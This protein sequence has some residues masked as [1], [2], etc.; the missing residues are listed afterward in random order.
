MESL[1]ANYGIIIKTQRDPTDDDVKFI[2][3]RTSELMS[4][5]KEGPNPFPCEG[6]GITI[7][8]LSKK[9]EI[10][11]S[12]GIEAGTSEDLDHIVIAMESNPTEGM[13][14]NPRLFGFKSAIL[15]DRIRTI[16]ESAKDGTKQLTGDRPGLVYVNL[17][18]IDRRL[19]DH[20][21]NRL[22]DPLAN[23]LKNNSTVSAVVITS[24]FYGNDGKGTIYSHKSRVLKNEN[25]RFPVGFKIIGE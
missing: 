22:N 3:D 10:I 6:I 8:F 4:N 23:L 13:I 19:T 18:M 1:G 20:D 2:L 15:P 9:D 12:T 7:R 21:F 14:R 17:N 24:D 25:A 16:I 5:G 11:K